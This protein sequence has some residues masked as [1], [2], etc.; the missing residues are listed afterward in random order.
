[1]NL[2]FFF[3]LLGACSLGLTILWT[4]MP[5]PEESRAID[6]KFKECCKKCKPEEEFCRF[7]CEVVALHKN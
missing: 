1:M 6:A 3:I 5:T 7:R 2:L 4:K